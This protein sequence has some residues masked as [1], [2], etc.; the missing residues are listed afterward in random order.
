MAIRYYKVRSLYDRFIEKVEMVTESGCWI[1]VGCCDSNGYGNLSKGV[2]V[3]EG[4]RKNYYAHR[5]AYELYKGSIPEGLDIDHLCRVRCCVNPD[6]LEAVCR[7]EN[8]MRGNSPSNFNS[9]KMHCIRGHRLEGDNLFFDCDG[10]RQCRTCSRM[11]KRLE[12]R[13]RLERECSLQ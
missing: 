4:Y 9:I 3:V 6:H 5:V 10:Y 7:K 11:R 1:W 13:R 8:V 12:K 2:K